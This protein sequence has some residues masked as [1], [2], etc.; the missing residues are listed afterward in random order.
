MKRII[1]I[2]AAVIILTAALMS[3]TLADSDIFYPVS[4]TRSPDGTEIRKVYELS[5]QDNPAGIPRSDFEQ[6]GFHYTLLDLLKQEQPEYEEMEYTETVELESAEKEMEAV[7]AL[8]PQ[9]REFVTEDG[10]SGLLRLKLDTVRVEPGEN[11]Y[12]NWTASATR[13][14]PGLAGQDTSQIP[15]S[16]QDRGYTLNLQDVQ[17]SADSTAEVDGYQMGSTY[18]AT[19]SYSATVL[20]SKVKN[21]IVTADYT[22]T[23]SRTALNK[24][25]YVAVFEGV[26]LNPDAT[27]DPTPELTLPPVQEPVIEPPR[28]T[29]DPELSAITQ[30]TVAFNWM[31]VWI[32]LGV[33]VLAGGGI[34]LALVL[35]RRRESENTEE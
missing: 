10:F 35:K 3:T 7:L 32:I 4:V 1:S 16:I 33:I 17:W 23:V 20:G 12:Y 27:P 11:E 6:A 13:T 28:I 29:M 5:P 19:A 22:G 8:L 2:F 15:K 30:S 21:Y 14:Y 24:V 18:T 9:E 25:R 34:G 26:N 31:Y